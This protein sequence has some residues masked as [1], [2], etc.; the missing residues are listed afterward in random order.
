MN[1][2]WSL[3]TR[4][5]V[6]VIILLGAIWLAVVASP[7]LEALVISALLAYLLDPLVRLLMRRARLNRSLAAAFV[8]VLFLLLLAGIPAAL[9]AVA[10]DQFHRLEVDFA[11]AVDALKRWMSQPIDVLFQRIIFRD[12]FNLFPEGKLHI[13]IREVQSRLGVKMNSRPK[14]AGIYLGNL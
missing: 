7:L 3:T 5:L 13:D 8:Y 6:I 10:V 14:P 4:I 1:T 12:A 2:T 11:A 9:G